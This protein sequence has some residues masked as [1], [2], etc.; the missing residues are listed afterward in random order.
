[1]RNSFTSLC[2]LF[3]AAFSGL[4]AADCQRPKLDLQ[5]PDGGTATEQDMNAVQQAIV[6]LDVKV[7]EYLRC[8]KG[9]ASQQSV[10]K[11]DAARERLANSYIE[12]HNAAVNE[13]AGLAACYNDQIEK[14]KKTGGGTSKK[15]ADCSAQLATAASAPVGDPPA[16]MRGDLVREADG[17]TT[18]LADGAWS[19]S[20]IRDE[21]PRRCGPQNDQICVQRAVFVRNGSSQSLECRGSITYEGTD[22]AGRESIEARAIVGDRAVRAVVLGLAPRGVNARTFEA[23]CS[24]RPPL[25][26]LTTPASCKYQ[27]VKPINISDYYPPTSR[28][29]GEEGPVVVEFGV[30]D[31]PASPSDVKVV[32]GS[33][34]PSLDQGAIEAVKA[35][36]MSSNCS[37]GRYRL[38]LNFQLEQ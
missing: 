11:D 5:I 19:Y 17:H 21:T 22:A 24:P 23:D 16:A 36:V 27:V 3:A 2:F 6:T 10:G 28:R 18:E 7:G 34:S 4:A 15:P 20:L 14:H 29:A 37:K 31:K 26:P 8:I 1:M 32:A 30:G 12:L 38:K 13:L 35:M 33:L 25:P 9:E